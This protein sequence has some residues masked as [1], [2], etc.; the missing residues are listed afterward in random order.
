MPRLA[1]NALVLIACTATAALAE[2]PLPGRRRPGPRPR[3]SSAMPSWRRGRSRS[4]RGCASGCSRPSRW[5]ATPSPSGSTSAAG[6]SWPRRSASTAASPTP[7]GTW[8]GS[9]TTWPAGPSTTAWPCSGSTSASRNSTGYRGVSDRVRLIEDTDGDGKADRASVFADGFDNVPDGPAAG[10][11]ARHGGRL[12]HV[13]PRP[14]VPPRR[15]RR[16][17]GRRPPVAVAR[18]RGPRQLPRPRPP[19][20]RL[21]PRRQALL[22]HRRPRL[23]RP[24]RGARPRLPR[25]R[26]GAPLRP[27]RLEPGDLRHRPPQPAGPGVRPVRQPVHR[28]QQLRQR[29]QG[30]LGPRRRGGRQR[31]ADRLPVPQ[32]AGHPRPLE[33]REALV[34]AVGRPGRLYRAAAGQHLRRPLGRGVRAGGE[35]DARPLPRPLLPL[36]LPRVVGPERRSDRSRWSPTGRRTRW[37]IP[38]SSSGASRPPTSTSAPTGPCT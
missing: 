9:T 25:H 7:G 5:S 36:R 33:R 24:D 10:V 18:L 14:L 12:V 17:Q 19:R 28:R 22:Q 8:P 4:P 29:R 6:S 15:R 37:S 31:L 27:R 2:P 38:T 1:R 23:Q 3:S 16:R 34:S 20:A 30:A 11:V 26:R 21:R 35:P 32:G 13:H